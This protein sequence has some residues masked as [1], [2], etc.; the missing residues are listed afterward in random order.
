MRFLLDLVIIFSDVFHIVIYFAAAPKLQQ[1]KTQQKLENSK[2]ESHSIF[3]S[4]PCFVYLL[5]RS[6]LDIF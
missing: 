6:Q 4:I 3:L 2:N 5:C 1:I